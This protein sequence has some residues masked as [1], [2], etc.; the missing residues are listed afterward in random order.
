M[1]GNSLKRTVDGGESIVEQLMYGMNS[2]VKS[3]SGSETLD[4]TLQEG[5]TIA[6]YNWKQYAATIGATGLE[7]RNNKG[8]AA[9]LNLLKSKIKQ[10][11]M[12]LRNTM[13]ADAF[14][15]G[16]GNGSK[17]LTGLQA[18]VSTTG[19]LGGLSPTTYTWWKPTSTS[20]GSFAAQGLASMR[21]LYNTLS[22]GN[23]K[24]DFIITTQSVYEFFESSLQPQER[25]T[26][27]K[28]ANS[29]WPNITFKGVPV[30]FDRD[31]PSG[32][33]YMLN[34]NYLNFVVHSDAD[35]AMGDMQTPINQ[36]V[37]SAQLIFQGNL[38]CSNRRMLGELTAITA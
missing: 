6:R 16:T 22:L 27:T 30:L 19:T 28:A 7:M 5:L 10:A 23:D 36:D 18:I 32:K 25:Y 13:N 12:S 38:T 9:M 3:Y 4:T 15:D 24:P 8:E 35:F 37:V 31:C 29:G 2:T 34:S 20:G 14:G 33:L 17:T 21:T 11:E 26:D 1:R